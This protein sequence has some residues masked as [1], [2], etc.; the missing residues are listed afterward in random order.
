MIS[1]ANRSG[2]RIAS[3]WAF[4]SSLASWVIVMALLWIDGFDSFGTSTGAAP[5]PTGV[6]GRK[7][8]AAQEASMKVQAGRFIGQ[9]LQLT[10]SSS[11]VVTKTGL[12]TNATVV[13]GFAVKFTNLPGGLCGFFAFMDGSS[14]GVYLVATPDGEIAV[15]KGSTA[16]ELGRTS[17]LGLVAGSWYWI[18]CKTY[19]HVSA[20][21][22]E[23]KLGTTTV[24]SLT[25]KNTKTTHDYHDGFRLLR[26]NSNVPVLDPYFD[27]LY[28]LD[29]SGSANTNF[30][31]NMKVTTIRPNGD[32]ADVD[33]TPSTGVTHYDLVDEE[34][35]VSTP[36]SDGD[37]V[38]SAVSTDKDLYDYSALV[39]ISSGIAGA[40]VST[41]CRET[42]ATSFSLKTVCKSGST[43]S[44]DS[45][46]A[47]GTQTLTTK[48]RV[49]ESNPAGG[50]WDAT[51]LDAAL[52]GIEVA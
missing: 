48:C 16:T 1:L 27:D 39:G 11:I 21:T 43:E 37:Y 46:Q 6:V 44:A 51:S 42:D 4:F 3:A 24:L 13:A 19:V 40:M 10:S 25:G 14:R 5:S 50:A 41:D 26:D 29:A 30:L 35:F 2:G 8:T 12:T 49:V 9:S 33:W 32:T 15:C 7:Y 18:Q 28:F 20:G 38:E 45:G 17:G 36:T 47:V 22:V 34:V 31:G 23:L 52:F